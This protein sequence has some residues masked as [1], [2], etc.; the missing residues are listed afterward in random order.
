[1]TQT[2]QSI[3]LPDILPKE[4]AHDGALVRE[5]E[6]IQLE[7]KAD[8]VDKLIQYVKWADPELHTAVRYMSLHLVD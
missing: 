3:S 4:N 7:T 8:R 2:L 5:L 6:E 1:M